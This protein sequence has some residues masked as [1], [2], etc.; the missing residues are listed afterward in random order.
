MKS[1]QQGVSCRYEM[2]VSCRYAVGVCCLYLCN[3]QSNSAP[4]APYKALLTE[5]KL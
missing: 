3:F 5:V 4:G 2:G 1:L